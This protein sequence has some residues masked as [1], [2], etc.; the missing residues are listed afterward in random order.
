MEMSKFEYIIEPPLSS[1]SLSGAI[2]KIFNL[3]KNDKPRVIIDDNGFTFDLLN[4]KKVLPFDKCKS[5]YGTAMLYKSDKGYEALYVMY[6]LEL[7]DPSDLDIYLYYQSPKGLIPFINNSSEFSNYM[8]VPTV[9]GIFINAANAPE[10]DPRE[11][12]KSKGLEMQR[13]RLVLNVD[14][15]EKYNEFIK[16]N[17]DPAL[18]DEYKL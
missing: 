15:V 6:F 4:E 7:K 5:L 2:K 18:Y 11:F 10:A 13:H 14:T 1:Y 9:P 17:V 3:S 12:F 16:M 8:G